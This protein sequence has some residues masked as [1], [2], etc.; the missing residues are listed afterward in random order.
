MKTPDR[1]DLKLGTVVVLNRLLKPIDLGSK[2]QGL[3]A[4]GRHF[5]HL[6]P[7]HVCGT[8]AVTKFKFCAQMYYGRLLPAAGVS[9]YNS[10]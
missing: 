1:Y 10:L 2:G 3:G 6:A 4:Q 8:D 7:L 9:E 5:E